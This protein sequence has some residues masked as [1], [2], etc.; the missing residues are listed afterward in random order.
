MFTSKKEAL[1]ALYND[2]KILNEINFDALLDDGIDGCDKKQNARYAAANESLESLRYR[3]ARYAFAS[4]TEDEL[5]ELWKTS[6]ESRCS[7]LPEEQY[8]H[9]NNYIQSLIKYLK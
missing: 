1:Q 9:I 8:A 5:N 7:Y 2:L 3:V 4:I 6:W